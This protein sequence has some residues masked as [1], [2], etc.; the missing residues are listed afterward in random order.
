MNN[1]YK[2]GIIP[3]SQPSSGDEGGIREVIYTTPGTYSWTCPE[4]VTSI[5]VVA[6]GGGGGSAS[7]RYTQTDTFVSASGEAGGAGYKNNIPVIPGQSY[8]VVVG[9]KGANDSVQ[10]SSLSGTNANASDG[11]DSYFID[12]TTVAGHGGDGGHASAKYKCGNIVTWEG[13]SEVVQVINKQ[14][15][16]TDLIMVQ[17]KIQEHQ[18]KMA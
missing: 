18:E 17:I 7:S 10:S 3:S 15:M 16:F 9:S 1:F 2:F 8:T 13:T 6:I 14:D 11:D 4:G 12:A 5:S